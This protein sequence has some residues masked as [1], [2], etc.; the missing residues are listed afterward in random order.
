[1]TIISVQCTG[2]GPYSSCTVPMWHRT[3]VLKVYDNE[4]G[5]SILFYDNLYADTDDRKR[6][7]RPVDANS[8]VVKTR[9][10]FPPWREGVSTP[11]LAPLPG[12]WL[13]AWVLSPNWSVATFWEA[14]HY[15]GSPLK[16]GV[17]S[18]SG[19]GW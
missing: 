19:A 10:G 12:G 1:V 14:F 5:S 13:A 8:I 16:L 2:T 7:T 11:F 3:A 18:Y 9:W 4:I 17:T 15:T 6:P